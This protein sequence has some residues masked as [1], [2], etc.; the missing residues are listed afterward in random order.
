MSKKSPFISY[1]V[2][3]IFAQEAVSYIVIA[4]VDVFNSRGDWIFDKKNAIRY[5]NKILNEVMHQLSMGNKK[6]QFN[7][8]RVLNNL[9]VEPL[10]I[11]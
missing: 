9:R 2:D 5:Y 4:G 3:E 1:T 11:H 10:R 8:R 6:Q 7:A